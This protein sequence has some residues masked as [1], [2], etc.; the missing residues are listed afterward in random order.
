MVKKPGIVPGYDCPL[1]RDG[2]L[3][4]AR[5]GEWTIGKYKNADNA[6]MWV[7]YVWKWAIRSLVVAGGQVRRA[8][9]TS[10]PCPSSA[11]RELYTLYSLLGLQST[12]LLQ[13]CTR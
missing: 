7:G 11:L 10:V 3:S 12:I 2:N 6:A 9:A 13:I 1:R 8:D 5:R 4:V